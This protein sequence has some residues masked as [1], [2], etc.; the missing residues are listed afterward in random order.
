MGG[1]IARWL[2][3]EDFEKIL[4]HLDAQIMNVQQRLAAFER[5]RVANLRRVIYFAVLSLLSY[6]VYWKWFL[7]M[8]MKPLYALM[9]GSLFVIL[10]ATMWLIAR[11]VNAYYQSRIRSYESWLDQLRQDQSYKLEELKRKLNWYN[12]EKLIHR[13]ESRL[14]APAATPLHPQ[15]QPRSGP[16]TP[17]PQQ[18]NATAF[19]K[20]TQHQQHVAPSTVHTTSHVSRTATTTQHIA[21]V[22]PT[23]QASHQHSSTAA[24]I[25]AAPTAES[26][27]QTDAGGVSPSQPTPP[28]PTQQQQQNQTA[29]REAPHTVA[30]PAAL[31]RTM[32]VPAHVLQSR[33]A[34]PR[35]V[36]PESNAQQS[37]IDKLVDLLIGESPSNSFALICE[38][39]KTNNGLAPQDDMELVEFVCSKCGHLNSRLKTTAERRASSPT[40][41]IS[42]NSLS[43]PQESQTSS[44]SSLSSSSAVDGTDTAAPSQ[45]ETESKK[46][47]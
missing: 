44:S 40:K 18:E 47:R 15:Q 37:W 23:Q 38:K 11:V 30:G 17:Q 45:P 8:H 14:A 10:P 46:D 12:T 20:T 34:P 43:T 32:P 2:G 42:G 16:N 41:S 29:R 27:P 22:A 33:T 19:N 24:P 31:P 21:P 5:S 6:A 26:R 13:Y 1:I 36:T 28:Q 25:N 7:P 4:E 3:R 35:P 39:C 9:Y